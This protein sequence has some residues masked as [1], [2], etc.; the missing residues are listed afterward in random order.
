MPVRERP[1]R[2]RPDRGREG[3]TLRLPGRDGG[4][5]EVFADLVSRAVVYADGVAEYR[6]VQTGRREL[7]VGI[8]AAGDTPLALARAHVAAELGSLADRLGAEQAQVRFVTYAPEP[9]RKLRRVERRWRGSRTMRSCEI[10]GWGSMLPGRTVRFGESVRY[11]IEDDVSHL[12]MLVGAAR[13]AI[14]HAGLTTDDVD[15]VLGAS[16]A[17]VQPIPCTAALVWER[18]TSAG[19]AAAFDVNSTCTSFVTAL[20]IASRYLDD[21]DHRTVLVVAGDVASRFLN[22]DQQESFELFSDA[23]VA[24][25]LRRATAPDRGVVSSLQQTWPAHAHDT[26]LRGGCRTRPPSST[27]RPIRPITS[28]TW[29]DGVRCSG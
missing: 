14:A 20:D 17:G 23:A 24:V 1:D 21:G 4:V 22:P 25:V 6:I 13:R 28:S 29:M 16:A 2:G 9:G 5:V 19:H 8:E 3:D 27:R 10:A 12:D 18:L 7:E 26:E 11:R 15:L